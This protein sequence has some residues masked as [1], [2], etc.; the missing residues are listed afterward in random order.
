M[1]RRLAKGAVG[2]QRPVRSGEEHVGPGADVFLHAELGAERV[3][4]L[5]E[6]GLDRGDQ[7]RMG[8]QRPVPAD[9]AL[10]AERL[11]IGR[12][13]QLDRGRV[14][15]DAVVEPVHLVFR[16]DPADGHHGHQDLDLGDL[17]RVAGEE[18]LDVMRLRALDD[19]V[20]PIARHVHARNGVHELVHLSDDD[21]ALERGG[22]DDDRRVF[23]VGARVEV[24]GRIRRLRGHE[25]D[26][27]RQSRRNSA[28][29]AQGRCGSP[30]WRSGP[31]SRGAPGAPPAALRT[32]SRAGSR[33]RARRCPGARATPAPIAP[34]AGRAPSPGRGPRAPWPGSRPASDCCLPGRPGRLAPGRAR[35]RRQHQG[36]PPPSPG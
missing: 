19:E 6:P 15:P 23:G 7:R 16:I 34:C 11:G 26:A 20:D 21:A 24:A 22:L 35:A 10:Q 30:R 33:R 14:E 1:P 3:D 4:V 29:T 13:Q 31:S 5:H 27:R 18:R 25:A 8:V 12:Q 36:P 9:L 17:G 2:A 28:R 32:R